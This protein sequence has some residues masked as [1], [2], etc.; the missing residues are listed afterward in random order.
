[1][2]SKPRP[3]QS[4]L[5]AFQVRT[6]L[7]KRKPFLGDLGDVLAPAKVGLSRA[8]EFRYLAC[9]ECHQPSIRLG[10]HLGAEPGR[11]DVDL[12]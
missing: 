2:T 1:M 4:F 11:R 7:G 6:E 8:L 9:P 12:P 10:F 5:E 3:Q